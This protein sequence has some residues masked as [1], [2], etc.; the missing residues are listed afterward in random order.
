MGLQTDKS[1]QLFLFSGIASCCG[2]I[3]TV[4]IDVVKVRMQLQGELGSVA[5]YP[6]AMRAFPM[7]V[8]EEGFSALYKGIQPALLRQATYGSLRIGMYEPIKSFVVRKIPGKTDG[9]NVMHKL[10]SGVICGGL[11]SALCNPTDVVKVRMQADGMAGTGSGPRYKNVFDAF[12]QIWQHEGVRGMYKGVSPTVQRAAIVAGV[13]LASYD[14]CKTLLVRH[15]Q[16]S[17]QGTATHLTASIMAGFLCTIASSPLDVIK[18]RVMNQPVDSTGRGLRYA[19][20]VD[21]FRSSVRAEGVLSLWKGFWPN[22]GEFRVRLLCI[23]LPRCNECSCC[24]KAGTTLHCHFHGHRT[25]EK[26][27]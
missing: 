15:L 1:W 25:V 27:F 16:F 12:S 6:S 20:T 7:I 8:Q 21:C 2:E 22:F 17:D 13:E 19:S 18:S 4:P 23:C 3:S 9:P 10:L 24:S 5:K 14:E 26:C 11:A